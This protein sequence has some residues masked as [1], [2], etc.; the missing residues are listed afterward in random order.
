MF[1]NLNFLL[2]RQRDRE[3]REVAATRR[4]LIS[5]QTPVTRVTLRYAAAA[6]EERLRWL[7]GVD[8][9]PPVGDCALVA[10]VDGRLRAA[11]DLDDGTVIADPFFRG[12]E[13]VALLR[14]R[15]SQLSAG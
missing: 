4:L 9:A 5:E 15:A 2:A 7:A 8:S 3:R 13:F 11:L 12:A 1:T 10:E 6:D 14:L